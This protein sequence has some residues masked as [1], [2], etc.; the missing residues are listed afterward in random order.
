[1]RTIVVATDP[2]KH[3]LV[4]FRGSATLYW[5]PALPSTITT[6]VASIGAFILQTTFENGYSMQLS[7]LNKIF[8]HVQA[9]I[10][11]NRAT[12]PALYTFVTRDLHF[13]T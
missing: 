13:K 6:L 12:L 9:A 8:F 2:L 5:T 11:T 7:Y 10:K 1:M 3:F 4:L